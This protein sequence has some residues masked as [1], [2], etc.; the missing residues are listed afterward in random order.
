MSSGYYLDKDKV[1]YGSYPECPRAKLKALENYMTSVRAVPIGRMR[2][3][4][5]RKDY[6][7]TLETY[8]RLR[9]K[10]REMKKE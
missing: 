6:V 9:Q 10:V 3:C 7:S 8:Y 5:Y 2:V 1:G 4:E